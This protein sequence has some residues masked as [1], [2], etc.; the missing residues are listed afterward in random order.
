LLPASAV[1]TAL[2]AFACLNGMLIRALCYWLPLPFEWQ[3]LVDSQ[4]VQMCLSILWTV[5]ALGIMVYA[6]RMRLREVWFVG[7][8]LMVV[9]ILKLFIF[10]LASAGSLERVVSF[11]VVGG[12]LLL[13]GYFSPLP[14]ATRARDAAPAESK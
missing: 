10:D 1:L 8:V 5:T 4:L 14:P 13:I 6:A 11:I 3:P 12:L 7:A 2:T 9:E